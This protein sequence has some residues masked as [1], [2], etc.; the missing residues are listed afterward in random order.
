MTF[1][2]EPKGFSVFVTENNFFGFILILVRLFSVFFAVLKIRERE[3][4]KEQFKEIKHSF[5]LFVPSLCL[6]KIEEVF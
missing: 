4:E 1:E 3:K 2:K 5:T 6:F